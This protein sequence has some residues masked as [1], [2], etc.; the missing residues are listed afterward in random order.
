[1]DQETEPHC[2]LLHVLGNSPLRSHVPILD[3]HHENLLLRH[4]N[5]ANS[6]SV[7]RQLHHHHAPRVHYLRNLSARTQ[8]QQSAQ[9][10][11]QA[12]LL[13]LCQPV[14]ESPRHL[15]LLPVL[16]GRQPRPRSHS[17]GHP[18]LLPPHH[19]PRKHLQTPR[20]VLQRAA[21]HQVHQVLP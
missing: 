7:H 5:P 8:L 17:P 6:R 12:H 19:F 10:G 13:H 9:P 2:L 15:P 3:Q 16:E 14:H 1:M 11:Q 20:L 21:V 18:R 4:F